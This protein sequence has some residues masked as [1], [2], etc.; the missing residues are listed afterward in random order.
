AHTSTAAPCPS[1]GI[2]P[3][4]NVTSGETVLT[5]VSGVSANDIWAVGYAGVGGAIQTV[6]EHW[7]GKAWTI[8][9]SPN[10]QP[11]VDN[12][13]DGVAAVSAN[14]VWAVGDSGTSLHPGTVL[15]HWDG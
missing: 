13:L 11:G 14:N 10:P 7:D 1:W 15:L 12:F 5:S 6:T 4:A 2:V 3:S 8:V 9:P